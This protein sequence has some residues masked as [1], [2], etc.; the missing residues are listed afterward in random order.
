MLKNRLILRIKSATISRT[1]KIGFDGKCG[2]KPTS[3]PKTGW[4][5]AKR[6]RRQGLFGVIDKTVEAMTFLKAELPIND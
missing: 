5:S 4:P 2:S 6:E 3:S 1:V